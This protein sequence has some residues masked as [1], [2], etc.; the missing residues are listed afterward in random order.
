[1]ALVPNSRMGKRSV[2]Y[3][4]STLPV[5]EIVSSPARL[6]SMV[7][8][9]ASMV[10]MTRISNPVVSWAGRYSLTFLISSASWAR[11]GSNQKMDG[12]PV[13][14]ALLTPSLTQS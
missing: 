12:V 8:A 3:S 9:I 7:Y 13:I 11:L 6:R 14:L 2:R 1:M 5:T 10:D 4:R